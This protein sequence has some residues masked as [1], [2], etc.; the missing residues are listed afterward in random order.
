M[1]NLDAVPIQ[2]ATQTEE[3]TRKH[4]MNVQLKVCNI[5]FVIKNSLFITVIRKYL[6]H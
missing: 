4:Q 3:Y 6:F 5:L 1:D 2:L